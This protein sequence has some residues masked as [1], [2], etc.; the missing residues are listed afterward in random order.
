MPCTSPMAWLH[1]DWALNFSSWGILLD[2]AFYFY[3]LCFKWGCVFLRA[4]S[5]RYFSGRFPS[6]LNFSDAFCKQKSCMCWLLNHSRSGE[7]KYRLLALGSDAWPIM[8]RLEYSAAFR[9]LSGVFFFYVCANEM[10]KKELCSL[11]KTDILG[12]WK[13]EARFVSCDFVS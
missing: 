5:S 4:N 10:E 9:E 11:G 6:I 1:M 8:G 12:I 2:L 7:L 13:V 3:L